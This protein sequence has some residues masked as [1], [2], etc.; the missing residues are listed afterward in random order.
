MSDWKLYRWTWI[1]DSP[2]HIG[3][4]PAGILDRT[5]LYVPARTLWGA[6]TAELARK[7]S[8]Q[9]PEYEKVG[10]ELRKK[11]RFSYLFPAQKI[12]G[13]WYPWLPK[14][15][16]DPGNSEVKGLA[17]CLRRGEKDEKIIEDREFR[18]WLL[19]TRPATAISPD[20]E[21]AEES[22]LREHEI[23]LPFSRWGNAVL[24]KVGLTGYVFIKKGDD[25][26]INA[27]AQLTQL[28]V[29][30]DIR[31]GQGWLSR[32][33]TLVE[34]GQFFEYKVCTQDVDHPGIC[35]SH[36]LAHTLINECIQISGN[37]E[38]FS[39]RDMIQ[40]WNALSTFRYGWV[41]G[42]VLTVPHIFSLHDQGIWRLSN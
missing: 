16:H 11:V 33:G 22:T 25:K 6:I 29:G 40:G 15:I 30:G 27:L 31:H 23:L 14:Y 9:F 26:V 2:I 19:Y 12:D 10:E 4:T 20:N 39:G 13:N 1:L 18:T 28:F 8:E 35:T 37:I 32:E 5:R 7:Q 17:W 34:E 38:S 21:V 3:T 24:E 41:P 42:S 36:L